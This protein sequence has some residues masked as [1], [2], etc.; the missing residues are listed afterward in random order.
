MRAV[1]Q[2]RYGTSGV[3]QV[4]ERPVPE[5][6]PGE[7]LIRVAAAALDRGTWHLMAGLPFAVR[8]AV[9]LRAP[10]TPVPGRDLAGE[11]TAVGPGVAGLAV[12]DAVFGTAPRGSLAEYAIAPAD[13]IAHAP[14][15]LAPE[16]AAALG[17]SGQTAW[18][19]VHT[20]G[21]VTAGASVLVLGA[22]GGV[23]T[24]AVQIAR[25]AGASV[26][27][28]CRTGSVD[29]VRGLGATEVIDRTSTD[30]AGL[31]RRWDVV[32]DIGG[33]PPVSRLR[34]L[35]TP[36]GTA[37]LVGGERP[38]ARITGGYGRLLRAAALSPLLRQRLV[39]LVASEN[40]T[41]LGH[42]RDLV[43]TGEL[44]P[45]LDRTVGLDDAGA[46]IEHLGSGR[47][48]GKIVVRIGSDQSADRRSGT[49][50]H[51]ETIRQSHST[52]P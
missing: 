10:R 11:I 45:V 36:R 37:V 46:A 32:L 28:V 24:F 21:R 6:G 23:G 9:G 14:A 44:T 52:G 51:Q 27:A 42:L 4:A 15:G 19:A 5:P 2:E 39:V 34:R 50:A 7:V 1:V 48:R 35:L 3:W 29:L 43:E 8:P 18:Q 25:A 38:D 17:V 47:A 20:A 33:N 31:G 49:G 13:R 26:T 41:D 40:S 30:V 22:S 16:A 12:G